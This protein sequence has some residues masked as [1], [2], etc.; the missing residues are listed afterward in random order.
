MLSAGRIEI[1][2]PH[3]SEPSAYLVKVGSETFCV[4]ELS[5][6]GRVSF[7]FRR[8]GADHRI[9]LRADGRGDVDAG[10]DARAEV[11]RQIHAWLVARQR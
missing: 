3:A 2:M 8:R 1:N 10:A 7:E 4:C 9:P 5:L 6:A 11:E